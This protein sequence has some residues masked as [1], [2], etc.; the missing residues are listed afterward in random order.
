MTYRILKYRL[1]GAAW[2]LELSET[3]IGT[4]LGHVQRSPSSKESVGQL[5]TKDLTSNPVVAEVATVLTP[6]RA[7][8]ARV[9]FSTDR[10][11]N[12]RESLFT[13]GLHCIGFWHTHP[14]PSPTP[15]MED[16]RLARDHS[17]AAKPQLSGIVFVIVG[18]APPPIGV[19][20]WIDDGIDLREALFED[21]HRSD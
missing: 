16:R 1:P 7:A 4:L 8:W 13:N 6:T 11:R 20:V 21:I 12:E 15:S 18:N 14:E 5:F 10:A 17:L 3:A 9:T 2:S 19:R